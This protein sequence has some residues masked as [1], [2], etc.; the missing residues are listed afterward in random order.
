MSSINNGN[1]KLYFDYKQEIKSQEFNKLSHKLHKNGIYSGGELTKVLDFEIRVQPFTLFHEDDYNNVSV[2]IETTSFAVCKV[3]PSTPYIIGRF[4]WLNTE[5]NYMDIISVSK[6]EIVSS[7]LVFGRGIYE[8]STLLNVFDYSERSTA[9]KKYLENLNA[10][11][12][13]SRETNTVVVS[14]KNKIFFNGKLIHPFTEKESEEIPNTSQYPRKDL[15][16][17]NTISNNI[18]IIFGEASDSPE[19]QTQINKNNLVIGILN[20]PPFSSRI[21]NSYIEIISLNDFKSVYKKEEDVLSIVISNKGN[22]IDAYSVDSYKATDILKS[23]SNLNRH[24]IKNIYFSTTNN[25]GTITDIVD[26]PYGIL[27]VNNITS[28]F[29][30]L[31][32]ID[33]GSTWTQQ[34]FNV[35]PAGFPEP[36]L[37]AGTGLVILYYYGSYRAAYLTSNNG[38]SWTSRTYPTGIDYFGRI[39]F[40]NNLFVG[41]GYTSGSN[42]FFITSTDGLSWQVRQ[43]ITPFSSSINQLSNIV[44]FNSMYYCSI[45]TTLYKS[46]NAITW[47]TQSLSSFVLNNQTRISHGGDKIFI[48]PLSNST[49]KNNYILSSNDGTNWTK[50]DLPY[51]IENFIGVVFLKNYYF[52]MSGSKIIIFTKDFLSFGYFSTT[53]SRI[54]V[55]NIVER[56][57]FIIGYVD[58]KVLGSIRQYQ[59][60]KL[61]IPD[62]F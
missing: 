1:Q 12:I 53:C 11:E 27:C 45:G 23:I 51:E 62:D 40:V 44:Y 7:D 31:R 28:P 50:I 58:V 25:I 19:F 48:S 38:T 26:S 15:I 14:I 61:I 47:T 5:E 13:K 4:I 37:V 2:R 42:G 18:E 16:T 46:S 60:Y 29:N 49:T 22:S 30:Y 24:F 32:S 21:K 43:S 9:N 10:F 55:S 52:L 17:L 41:I 3:S 36:K 20:L 8:G 33:N 6:E 57:D 35:S 59:L 34:T 56:S 39:S 54:G